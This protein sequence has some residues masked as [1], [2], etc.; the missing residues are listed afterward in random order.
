MSSNTAEERETYT[1]MLLLECKVNEEASLRPVAVKE[2][3][4][5]DQPS[6]I[7]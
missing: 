5:L 6:A 2:L 4:L 1:S 7:V 3:M